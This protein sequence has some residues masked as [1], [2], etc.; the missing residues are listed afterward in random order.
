[1]E[2]S[3]YS[4]ILRETYLAYVM[5]DKSLSLDQRNGGVCVESV[6]IVDG[7]NMQ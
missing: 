1:M 7:T 5:F 3:E 4:K 2:Y 6:A